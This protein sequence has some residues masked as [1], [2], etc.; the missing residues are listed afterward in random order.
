[1]AFVSVF[2]ESVFFSQNKDLIKK[3]WTDP[4][5]YIFSSANSVSIWNLFLQFD[6][7][8][9]QDLGQVNILQLKLY[10]FY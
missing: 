8:T 1:M 10:F 3:I 7:C 5:C 6:H 4:W 9:L 2:K